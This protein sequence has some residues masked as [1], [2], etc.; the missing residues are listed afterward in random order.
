M[1]GPTATP[2]AC[3]VTVHWGPWAPTGTNNGMVTP[4]LM[5]MYAARGIHL[6]DPDE[7]SMNLLREL[8]WGPQE[9]TAVVYTASGW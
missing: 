3:V 7:G 2:A 1:T 5:R 4:E 9:D 6:I 8:A